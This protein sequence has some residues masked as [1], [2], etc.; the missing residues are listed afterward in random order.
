MLATKYRA[1]AWVR[2]LFF[3]YSRHCPRRVSHLDCTG[4]G[5]YSRRKGTVSLGTA[6]G[7]FPNQGQS[8]HPMLPVKKALSTSLPLPLPVPQRSATKVR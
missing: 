5:R 4:N 3:K 6:S 8:P 1:R 2:Y 7:S